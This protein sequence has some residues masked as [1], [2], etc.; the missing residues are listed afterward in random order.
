M[1]KTN[2]P[3][4]DPVDFFPHYVGKARSRGLELD[5]AG[6][7][8][9]RV[10]VQASYTANQTIITD[11][12]VSGTQGKRL[13]GAA[14][15][16]A[17]A[18]LKYDLTPDAASGLSFGAGATASAQR[19]G[20]DFNTWQLPGYARFDLMASFRRP[21]GGALLT[22][23]LN[24]VNVSDKVYFDHGGYGFAAYGAPRTLQGAI[25]VEF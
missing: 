21:V 25:R 14:P 2:I 7:L 9:R 22:A 18:W 8:T 24:I 12:P 16:F 5:V 23:R 3:E 6:Q 19:Q 13:S 17:S 10:S 1:T 15:Q 4:Y 20:D 11:D